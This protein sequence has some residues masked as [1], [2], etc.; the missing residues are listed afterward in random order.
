M[1]IKELHL[2]FQTPGGL[3][4]SLVIELDAADRP[5][6]IIKTLDAKLIEAGCKPKPQSRAGGFVK[7]EKPP[8]L[9]NCPTCQKK[10]IEKAGVDKNTGRAWKLHR[11]PADDRHYKEFR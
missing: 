4:G 1:K 3:D 11:C 8:I 6:E 2:A 5:S 9:E 10:I 7:K